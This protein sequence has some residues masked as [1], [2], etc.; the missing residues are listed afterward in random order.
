MRKLLLIV[1]VLV[2]TMSIAA[3][4][5]AGGGPRHERCDFSGPHPLGPGQ[6]SLNGR[7]HSAA[8]CVEPGT[9]PGIVQFHKGA[10]VWGG[11]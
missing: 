3:P 9:M 11:G 1:F 5:L 6:G 10:G 7:L 4:A 2:L 8:A